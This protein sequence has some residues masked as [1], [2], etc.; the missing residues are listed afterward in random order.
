MV[1]IENQVRKL[2]SRMVHANHALLP[3]LFLQQMIKME[4]NCKSPFLYT[5]S[6]IDTEVLKLSSE[7]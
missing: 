5:R 4:L 1:S 3:S 2:L 6:L 7:V